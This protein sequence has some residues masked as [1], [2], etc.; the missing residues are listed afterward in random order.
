MRR[1][2]NIIGKSTEKEMTLNREYDRVN[3]LDWVE[4]NRHLTF[5]HDIKPSMAYQTTAIPSLPA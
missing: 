3:W 2:K 4:L 1:K 5:Q